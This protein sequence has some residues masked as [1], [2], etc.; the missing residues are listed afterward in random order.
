MDHGIKIL[1]NPPLLPT[2]VGPK[3]QNQYSTNSPR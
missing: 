1:E 2:K 3:L